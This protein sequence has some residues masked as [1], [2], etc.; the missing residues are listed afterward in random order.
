MTGGGLKK[1]IPMTLSGRFVAVA[2]CTSGSEEVFEARIDLGL[3]D[4]VEPPEELDLR[5]EVLGDGL[6]HQVGAGEVVD[7]Q[8]VPRDRGRGPRRARPPRACPCSTALPERL[9]DRP[10]GRARAGRRR[11][12]RR[13]RPPPALATTSTMPEP[14]MPQPS[15]PTVFTSSG[16][17]SP[18]P[19]DCPR[20][21]GS[22][23]ELRS[24]SS[25]GA[26]SGRTRRSPSPR[27]GRAAPSSAA[28]TRARR[29]R[30]RGRSRRRP[31]RG[32][33]PG[34]ARGAARTWPRRC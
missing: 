31:C 14:M 4:L 3:G 21:T 2:I 18:P 1:C 13:S 23:P 27:R 5:V 15:T 24:G 34:R 32:R 16:F 8:V 6:D 11:A 25:R 28:R 26:G 12:R 10:S 29:T 22:S 33:G 20:E 7:A 9:L 17:I 30:E 19:V